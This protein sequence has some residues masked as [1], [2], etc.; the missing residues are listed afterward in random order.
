MSRH[1]FD[2]DDAVGL[3]KAIRKAVDHTPIT[4]IHTHLYAPE[5][6]AQLLWGIDDLLTYHYLVA[7]FFRLSDMPYARFW[8]MDKQAQADL[9]WK[10]LFVDQTP[11]SEACRGVITVLDALGLDPSARDLAACRAWFARQE[12]AEH[13]DRVFDLAGIRRVIMTND[14]FDDAERAVWERGFSGDPRFLAA[15]RIDPLLNDW[16]K[17]WPRLRDWGFAVNAELDASGLREVRHFLLHWAGRMQAR[18]MAV[19]LP[20]D[21]AWPEDTPRARLLA[22]AVLPAAQEA[23]IPFAMMI[24]VKRQVNPAL[25]MAGDGVGTAELAPV[26]ALCAAFPENRFMATML[27]RENQ[28]ALCVAARKFRNLHVFGCWWFLNN[29]SIIE[30][31]TRQ[32]FELLGLSYTPQ[33]SDARV[34]D[35][36][37]YKW[38]HSRTIIADV[39][40]DK[41]TDLLAT[42]W[43]I[44][45][46]EIRRDVADLLGGAFEKFCAPS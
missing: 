30:E 2:R 1:T 24:G 28:H 6:G 11:L 21:F 37:I 5:F 14:P 17:A 32:R 41:Y 4:D 35:Q 10:T 33:H 22:E 25:R 38:A 40:A 7:E 46:A 45:E 36:L 39:L 34:L 8:A 19:S 18:Y 15:L 27:A 31:M 42:G 43:T 23:G 20:P 16:A 29:P 26:E 13:L 44:S 9:I 3:R 12:P